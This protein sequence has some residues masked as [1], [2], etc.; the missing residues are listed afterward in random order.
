MN[1]KTL[2][3]ASSMLVAAPFVASAQQQEITTW[4]RAGLWR[5]TIEPS[6]GGCFA[7]SFYTRPVI[8][9]RFGYS[10]DL[11]FFSLSNPS[12]RSLVPGETY[13]VHVSVDGQMPR[14]YRAMDARMSNCTVM[15]RVDV[16]NPSA[17]FDTIASAYSVQ[18]SYRGQWLLNAVLTGSA[19][20]VQQVRS[21][22]QVNGFGSYAK[23]PADLFSPSGQ[24]TPV[25]PAAPPT[26]PFTHL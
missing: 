14:T 1:T 24:A 3:L 26:D 8:Y 2:A 21:C 13:D 16:T 11:G 4:S 10:G 17:M 22:E 19:A 25:A 18:V 15:L 12:W 20:A 7:D 5:I 6:V 9:I 23:R